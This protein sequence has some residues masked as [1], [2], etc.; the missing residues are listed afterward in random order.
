M[1][2]AMRSPRNTLGNTLGN[3]L[4]VLT[5]LA[6]ALTACGKSSSN[7]NRSG[8]VAAIKAI[9]TRWRSDFAAKDA[10][11]FAADYAADAVAMSPGAAPL[12]GRAAIE[13]G[14]R[15]TFAEPAAQMTFTS[16]KVEVSASGDL[17]VS[18]GTFTDTFTYPPAHGPITLRGD[19]VT[20][21]KKQADGSWKAA[22]DISTPGSGTVFATNAKT[23]ARHPP[24]RRRSRHWRW[25]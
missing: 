21:F 3:T 19:Y 23:T 14:E 22:Y 11:K 6:A 20:V 1:V 5:C 8:D 4:A 17:A 10:A 15:Q 12:V 7:A 16:T 9:E 2:C 18:H 13:S 24:R 25:R